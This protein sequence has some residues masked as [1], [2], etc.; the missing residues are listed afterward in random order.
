[1]KYLK[2]YLHQIKRYLPLRDREDTLKELKSI[3]LDQIDEKVASGVDEEEA[4]YTTIISMGEPRTVAK[5]YSDH[6][7]FIS[8]EMEPILMLVLKIVSITLP[9]VVLFAQSIEFVFNTTDFTFMD[10]LLDLTYNIPSAMYSLVVAI[11][12]I[13]IFFMLIERFVQPKF[14]TEKLI[15]KPELLPELPDKEFKITL[16]E[17][18]VT[19]LVTVLALYIVNYQQGIISVYYDDVREPLLNSNFD[20]ILP[21]INIGWFLGISIHVYYLFTRKKNIAS[22]T[23][24][25]LLQIYGAVVLILLATNNIFN[26]IVV[27][28]YGFTVVEN[29]LKIVF[30][31]IAV[32][33]IIGGIV[34][35]VKMFINIDKL[36]ELETENK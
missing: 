9:I 32:A 21:F 34:E 4:E 8:D 2:S 24:E 36:D 13:F 17:S 33:S 28:G 16:F 14:E 7:P 15:F 11:G 3:I 30:I 10:F 29:I 22:K 26:E 6:R 19:I 12:F 18:I 27:D 1:M 20:R 23:F 5:G 25:L 35:Y 31:V